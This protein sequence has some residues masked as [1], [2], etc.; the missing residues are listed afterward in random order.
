VSA[1]CRGDTCIN[2]DEGLNQQGEERE[3]AA[4]RT[5]SSI[6]KNLNAG[7]Y[8]ARKAK[9]SRAYF[10]EQPLVPLSTLL[11]SENWQFCQL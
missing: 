10:K 8:K 3:D 9:A 7:A 5:F 1:R 6:H 11:G 2:P 4:N